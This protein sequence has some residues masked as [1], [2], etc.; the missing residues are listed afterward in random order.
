MIAPGTRVV[1]Y[2]YTDQGRIKVEGVVLCRTDDPE[3][4]WQAYYI[5]TDSGLTH[6]CD[7]QEV[8]RA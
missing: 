5:Q 1:G 8:Y 3:E 7:E 6:C 4:M 2:T